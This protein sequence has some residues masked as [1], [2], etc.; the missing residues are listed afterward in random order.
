[1]WRNGVADLN[2]KG[3]RRERT[4]H[5]LLPCRGDPG[6]TS[7][8]APTSTTWAKRASNWRST[9]R[10]P[11]SP[12]PNAYCATAPVDPVKNL[13]YLQAP[14]RGEDIYLS[15]DLRLQ[16]LAYRELKGAVQH[17]GASSGSLVMLDAGTGEV[18][19]LA[20][21]PSF[22]PN[23]WRQRGDARRAQPRHHRSVRA[24][25]HRQ[26]VYRAWPLWKA[27]TTRRTRKWI[28]RLATFASAGRRSKIRSIAAASASR[29]YW[30]NPVK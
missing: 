18:L 23:N 2:I 16:F 7:S 22:N 20:N 12:A 21:Q 11:A 1:M 19:A 15:L 27:A 26:A 25:L 17:H 10:S 8:D 6:P 14:Q 29:G 30:P 9:R 4:Y 28:P 3:V 13:D 5:R 24:R